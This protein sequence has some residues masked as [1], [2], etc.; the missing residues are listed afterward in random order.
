MF[1]DLSISDT[2]L[3]AETQ[4][5]RVAVA[6][7]LGYDGFAS[8]HQAS[9]SIDRS[10]RTP[11]P[12]C[13]KSARPISLTPL[14]CRC[15]IRK[16]TTTELKAAVKGMRTVRSQMATAGDVEKMVQ[17]SR[18]NLQ[19]EDTNEA[20]K[21]LSNAT[22]VNS[23]DIL[24]VQPQSERAFAYACTSLDV[25]LISL[26]LSKRLNFKFKPDAIQTA[27]KRGVQF[28]I[29]YA[30]LIRE[31]GSRRQIYANAQALA[32][33]TRGRSIVLS[34]GARAAIE[35]RGP[36]DVVNIATFLGLTESQAFAA[37]GKNAAAA[38]EHATKRK[39]YRGTLTMR[40]S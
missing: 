10:G 25:D 32:R 24:A 20:Q 3:E 9:T 39:A 33:E 5:E 16:L 26:D 31:P 36:Y 27:M 11:A 8:P 19:I 23:Y 12:Q 34:S 13:H 21:A 1:Y 28:E 2:Q 38:I 4:K 6:F 22:V 30:P 29:L 35:L 37:V 14:T 7:S 18:L 17:L 15:S 40:V